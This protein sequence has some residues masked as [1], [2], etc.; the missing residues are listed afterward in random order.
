MEGERVS[1]LKRIL[2]A[3]FYGF[4]S[5]LIVI[6]NKLVLTSYGFPSFQVLGLG[7]IVASVLVLYAAKLTRIIT[8][9]DM[10]MDTVRKVG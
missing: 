4:S 9:P 3:L 10:S 7:Q 5:M 8:Y 1:V 6:I 2:A